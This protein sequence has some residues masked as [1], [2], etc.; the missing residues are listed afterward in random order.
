[1]FLLS[2]I[3]VNK[4]KFLLILIRYTYSDISAFVSKCVLMVIDSTLK[5]SAA[6]F[7]LG[8]FFI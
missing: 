7:K 3:I 2:S 4:S 8:K 5:Y 1:M 6:N